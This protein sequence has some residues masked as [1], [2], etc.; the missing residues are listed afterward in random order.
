MSIENGPSQ[1][2]PAP[3]AN[4]EGETYAKQPLGPPGFDIHADLKHTDGKHVVG[5]VDDMVVQRAI[6]QALGGGKGIEKTSAAIM[7]KHDA[8]NSPKP[9]MG[10]A[11]AN[12]K[13]AQA[14]APAPKA[15]DSF[16]AGIFG[17]TAKR[18]AETRNRVEEILAVKNQPVKV[19]VEHLSAEGQDKIGKADAKNTAQLQGADQKATNKTQQRQWAAVKTAPSMGGMG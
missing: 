13:A 17:E 10:G 8:I 16:D 2:A 1:S 7:Q 3:A 9:S 19:S 6:N 12:M 11:R 18:Q 14:G 15:T 5:V 4:K